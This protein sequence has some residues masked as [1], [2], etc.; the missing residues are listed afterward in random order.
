[1]LT[2]SKCVIAGIASSFIAAILLYVIGI[3]LVLRKH[4]SGV[5]FDPIRALSM[6][7]FISYL[8]IFFLVGVFLTYKYIS[9]K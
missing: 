9:K 6:P 3:V 5:G 2:Y 8:L 4:E 1:M 7:G